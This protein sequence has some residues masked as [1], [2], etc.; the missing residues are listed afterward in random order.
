M[1]PSAAP[2]PPA[3]TRAPPPRPE[4]ATRTRA[5]QLTFTPL[6]TAPPP[7]PA[8]QSAPRG[9]NA[10]PPGGTEGRGE[11]RGYKTAAAATP[12]RCELPAGPAARRR[13]G[14]TKLP[15]GPG[16]GALPRA[17]PRSRP[18]PAPAVP[19]RALPP[20]SSPSG[21][22]CHPQPSRAG[23]GS[24]RAAVPPSA[25]PARCGALGCRRPLPA[26]LKTKGPGGHV[27]CGT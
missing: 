14:V 13:S 12:D 3:R 7:P 16:S 23:P 9:S 24:P 27:T 20:L 26:P 4:A 11:T 10:P 19:P 1:R 21:F 15:A 5:L 6:R 2:Q 18:S 22:R 17:S 25:G 8:A